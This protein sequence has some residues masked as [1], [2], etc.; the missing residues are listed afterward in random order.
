M[1]EITPGPVFQKL[2]KK[3]DDIIEMLNILRRS[4]TSLEE[5]IQINTEELENLRKALN[6]HLPTR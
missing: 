1:S 2:F 3:S 5:T 4:I 6:G